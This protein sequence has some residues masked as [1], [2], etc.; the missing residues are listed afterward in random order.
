MR[1]GRVNASNPIRQSHGPTVGPPGPDSLNSALRRNIEA[2]RERRRHDEENAGF[3]D[4]LADR[5][6]GFTGSMLFV[7][8][9]LA[10]Y[11]FWIVANLGWVPG[12]PPWDE[13]F[14]VL[15]MVASVEAIF[16]ST[17]VLI[18]QNRMMALADQRADLD[19][20]ISLLTEHEVTNL[21]RM[22]RQLAEHSGVQ[23][24]HEEV[25]ELERNVAPEAV[26][27]ALE[28]DKAADT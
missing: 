8:L 19:L 28:E 11:G 22:V 13:T 12:V 9:H 17:F 16:L 5:I 27:D 26:L 20:Q 3:S 24:K 15:A 25:E 6:T 1:W 7:F 10:I 2:L 21:V 14:V 4:R 23:V 18:S